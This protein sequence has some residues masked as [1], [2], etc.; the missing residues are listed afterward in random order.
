MDLVPHLLRSL[1][2]MRVFLTLLGV[3]LLTSGCTRHVLVV[4]HNYA[5]FED[6]ASFHV[7]TPDPRKEC[8]PYGQ[9]L[10]VTWNLPACVPLDTEQGS[11]S[12]R[13]YLRYGNRETETMTWPLRRRQG[14]VCYELLDQAY[15]EK[16]GI[17]T[18]KAQIEAGDTP[19][20]CWYHQLWSDVILLGEDQVVSGTCE[21]AAALAPDLP[22]T[23]R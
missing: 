8:P 15:E 20:Y 1:P 2:F 14:S 12:L 17:F 3:V 18:Y 4:Q 9:R 6:L 16:K 23:A 21:D 5:S 10:M 19:L 22:A 11:L 7:D 13:L